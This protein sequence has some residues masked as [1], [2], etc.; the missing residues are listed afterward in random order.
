MRLNDAWK[1]RV[2]E[3]LHQEE[4]DGHREGQVEV[5]KI[6]PALENLRKQHLWGDLN[7]QEYRAE[8]TALERRLKLVEGLVRPREVPNLDRAAALLDD[9]RELW[10]HPGVTDEQRESLI[11]EVSRRISID[12][13]TLIAIEPNPAYQPLFAAVLTAP[14]FGYCT[15]E[16][17]RLFAICKSPIDYT[18]CMGETQSGSIIRSGSWPARLYPLATCCGGPRLKRKRR[19][20]DKKEEERQSL[21]DWLKPYLEDPA[22]LHNA[23]HTVEDLRVVGERPNIGLLRLAVRS[24]ALSRPV[25]V[26]VN[27]PPPPWQDPSGARVGRSCRPTRRRSR[28]SERDLG[29]SSRACWRRPGEGSS[30]S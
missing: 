21:I 11:K 1:I 19:S 20:A 8:R 18:F 24:R 12:G 29:S 22:V 9:L 13:K 26:E 4:A 7:D 5:Q 27:S 14:G 16:S 10:S 30:M 28:P 3:S 25:N 2:M 6:L 15:P 17:G 23:I